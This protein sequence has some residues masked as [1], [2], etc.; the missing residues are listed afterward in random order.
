MTAV[1]RG[2]KQNVIML[3]TRGAKVDCDWCGGMSLL[4]D[5]M[6]FYD[7]GKIN[8]FILTNKDVFL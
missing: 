2:S 7:T 3:L 1:N 5:A 6:N 8:N 4:A